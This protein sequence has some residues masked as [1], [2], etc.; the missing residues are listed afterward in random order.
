MNAGMKFGNWMST[1]SQEDQVEVWEVILEVLSE[2]SK[3]EFKESIFF[4][5]SPGEYLA[6]AKTFGSSPVSSKCPVC[7][8]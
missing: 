4:G 5:S 8:K 1:L 7:G 3:Q 2:K 6:K